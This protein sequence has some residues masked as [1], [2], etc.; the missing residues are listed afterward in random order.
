MSFKEKLRNADPNDKQFVEKFNKDV[1]DAVT[2]LGENLNTRGAKLYYQQHT[3]KMKAGYFEQAAAGRAELA[4]VQTVTN[5]NKALGSR[6][7]VVMDRPAELDNK[8]AEHNLDIDN[9]VKNGFVPQAKAI[10]LKADGERA[11]YR[12]ALE[13]WANLDPEGTIEELK[14]GKWDEN[15]DATVK[16]EMLGRAKQVI[17]SRRIDAETTKRL[18]K[19][20][21]EAKQ[22]VTEGK[23]FSKM[24]EGKLTANDIDK[25][26]IDPDKQRVWFN[27]LDAE[28]AAGGKIKADPGVIVDVYQR[29]RLPDG[30]PRK[31]NDENQ[32][33]ELFGKGLD[34]ENLKFLRDEFQGNDTME[35]KAMK[36][37]RNKVIESA[38]SALIKAN[39]AI[40]LKDPEGETQMA[41]FLV[42]FQ[43]QYAEQKKRG[44][45]DLELLAPDS[46]DYLGKYINNY[47][48]TP[49][50]II[51]DMSKNFKPRPAVTPSP[52]G[53]IPE[54]SPSP[55][56]KLTRN[57]GETA[58]QFL[59]RKKKSGN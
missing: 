47:S 53:P 19:E 57:P 18:E 5:Y 34:K 25:S 52:N 36:T 2:P 38:E 24:V 7:A 9:M 58:A 23:M 43:T 41:K 12:S 6:S 22:K 8:L 46:P 51:S 37:L 30:D 31:I 33:N 48:R 11:L 3:A 20:A 54:G 35:G 14:A 50:Q 44:K 42:M 49:K 40:G 26:G 1:E 27:M 10:E 17:D 28:N 59:E 56:P 55:I 21:L 29:L 15:I 39:P 32:I 45:T 4:A 13:G 16:R